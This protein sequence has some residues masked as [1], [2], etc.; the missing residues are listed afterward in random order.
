MFWC[1]LTIKRIAFF[2][3]YFGLR[4]VRASQCI[5]R[6]RCATHT[7]AHRV[8]FFLFILRA[9]V[10]LRKQ[11]LLYMFALFFRSSLL[12]RLWCDF[13]FLRAAEDQE[14]MD[15]GAN[16]E[17]THKIGRRARVAAHTC[18][19]FRVMHSGSVNVFG[20]PH[21]KQILMPSTLL[22]FC[23]VFHFFYFTFIFHLFSVL[24]W[25]SQSEA[26]L[27]LHWKI[28]IILMFEVEL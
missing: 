16:V 23:H 21:T 15:H 28:T 12:H 9:V 19:Y 8:F 6:S 7:Y 26:M 4:F 25:A 18:A 22:S 11:L 1:C 27:C 10:R 14:I 24:C 17:Q 3:L 2:T 5:E 20:G 13:S